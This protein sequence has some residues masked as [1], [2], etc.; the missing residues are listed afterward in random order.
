MDNEALQFVS[1]LSSTAI[2]G[3]VLYFIARLFEPLVRE[4]IEARKAAAK[5]R[6]E[7]NALTARVA[8]RFEASDEVQKRS[9]SALD[10]LHTRIETDGRTLYQGITETNTKLASLPQAIASST[11][12]KVNE[13]MDAKLNPI[14]QRLSAIEQLLHEVRELVSQ[15]SEPD[16]PAAPVEP[17]APIQVDATVSIVTV[18]EP[19]A[20]ADGQPG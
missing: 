8:D 10:K 5:A 7:A 12:E 18:P 1:N 2:L 15:Q 20:T 19:E 13:A 3:V 16:E 11:V 4:L 6:E 9:V 14:T 17:A